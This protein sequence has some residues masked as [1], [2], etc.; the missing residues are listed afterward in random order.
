MH[1]RVQR[2]DPVPEDRREAGELGD[3]GDRHAGVG[4]RRRRAAAR[5][6]L[7]SRA[8]AG[9]RPARRRRTCRRRRAAR[10]RRH[11]QHLLDELCGVEP[12]LD[13]L[14][15]LVQRRLV[16]VRQDRHRLLGE[17]RAV[18]RPG[19]GHVNVAVRLSPPVRP[20]SGAAR[21]ACWMRSGKVAK[22]RWSRRGVHATV[23]TPAR[24][25]ATACTRC[26]RTRRRTRS[27]RP[28]RLRRRPHSPRP[29]ARS[30]R[31]SRPQGEAPGAGRLEERATARGQHGEARSCS[32]R[33]GPVSD[34]R[35]PRRHL[36]PAPG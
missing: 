15:A 18:V 17:D 31:R 10:S 27:A 12:P 23:P 22:G 33:P 20:G 2:D 21:G 13:G 19:G 3:V 8:R 5:Q 32:R 26:S 25:A 11:G 1:L 6:E 4:D 16:V 28:S 7:A 9:P 14:D 34:R 30:A 36:I 35:V 29:A 24:L